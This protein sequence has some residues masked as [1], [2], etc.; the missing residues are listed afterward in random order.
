MLAVQKAAH[1][2][3][4]TEW[5]DAAKTDKEFGGDKLNENLAVAKKALETFG[6][7]EL[8]KLLNDTGLGNNP[9]VIRMLFRAGTKISQGS[10]VQGSQAPQSQ[11]ANAANKLYPD[12]T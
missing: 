2:K 12:M 3:L 11:N 8:T 7:P 1:D 6:T 10:F 9:E 4:V 5:T